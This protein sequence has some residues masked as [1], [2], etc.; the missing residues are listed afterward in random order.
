MRG[1]PPRAEGFSASWLRQREPFDAV[2]R[3][4][5]ADRLRLET[6]LA[7]WRGPAD[8]PLRVVDLACGTGA[9]L[10]WLAPRLGGEQQWLV[11]DHDAALLRRW[12][13]GAAA[14]AVQ[15]VEG[16]AQGRHRRAGRSADD[17]C[18][19][20]AVDG[21]RAATLHV[22][23]AGFR[24]AIV[25]RRLD[26]ARSLER[27]PWGA[28]RLVTASALLD[29]V[30][31]A[32]LERL[33][34]AAVGA[35]VALL[36]ALTVDG[37]HLWAPR[38]VDDAVVGALFEAHQRRDKGFGVPAL[39][40]CAV[41]ALATA[42]RCNG[43]RVHGAR[44]DWVLDAR[45]DPAALALQRAM[46]DGIAQAA[47]EQAPAAAARVRAWLQRRHALAPCSVLR[48]GHRDLL[49]LPPV[50]ESRKRQRS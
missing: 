36:M 27:L 24:A 9:N 48:V 39:G 35:R 18:G 8:S 29:L 32:W 31:R 44:S 11:V 20:S 16:D 22:G 17:G 1:R 50:G 25:R 43:Y 30:S 34:T 37:R 33:V 5:A 15:P 49:A 10:R 2:A 14:G 46:V 7:A 19:V 28:A 38:D 26:L 42:L 45:R 40:A 12:P 21:G 23:T 47:I 41:P 3:A 4:A 13:D 6:R